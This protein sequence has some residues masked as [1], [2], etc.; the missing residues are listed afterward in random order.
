MTMSRRKYSNLMHVSIFY[1]D[2]F[3]YALKQ[4]TCLKPGIMDFAS[5][6]RDPPNYRGITVTSAVYKTYCHVLNDRLI[7][8]VELNDKI[9]DS[10]NGFRRN[11]STIDQLSTLTNIIECRKEKEKS[12]YVAYVDYSKAYDKIDRNIRGVIQN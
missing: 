8:W 4:E 6:L 10:Q 5:D 9:A 1:I 2:Y 3:A 11:R 7:K 12:T